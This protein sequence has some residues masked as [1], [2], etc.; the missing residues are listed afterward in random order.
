MRLCVTTCVDGR[1]QGYV[2]LWVYC[3]RRSYPEYDA[4]VFIADEL[5]PEIREALAPFA[6]D[7]QVAV[8]E[9]EFAGYPTPHRAAAYYRFLLFTKDRAK[10]FWHGYNAVYVTDGDL[11]IVREDPPLYEQHLRH[12]AAAKLAY[13]NMLRP[14]GKL[15]TDHMTGL[16]FA[17]A[18]HIR[19]IGSMSTA[20]DRRFREQGLGC[21]HGGWKI[22]DERLLYQIV[23][24][25]L[26]NMPP[27]LP[28]DA[29][30][31][32]A[33][34]NAAN[35]DQPAFRPEHG[36]N[37][38]QAVAGSDFNADAVVYTWPEHRALVQ[39][40]VAMGDD[41]LF[42]QCWQA[43]SDEGRRALGRIVQ[44]CG[45]DWEGGKG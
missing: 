29:E 7:R 19:D 8:V 39:G 33:A 23:K 9:G 13:S 45:F 26:Q 44:A 18:D 24:D 4:K 38:G 28:R 16:H 37:A 1:F 35:C 43:L 40:L 21:L 27:Y 6:G 3:L 20:Y 5:R 15:R 36:V 10:R 14:W 11:M 17:T 12:M 41:P 42:W 34:H 30:G 25:A 31:D 32:R 22:G 2:P